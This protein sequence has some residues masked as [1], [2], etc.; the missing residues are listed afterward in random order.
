ML[1]RIDP[2]LGRLILRINMLEDVDQTTKCPRILERDD[3]LSYSTRLVLYS[4]VAL[5]T[6]RRIIRSASVAYGLS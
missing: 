5:Y 2:R 3:L 1:A 4:E 6:V